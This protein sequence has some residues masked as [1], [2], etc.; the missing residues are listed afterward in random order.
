MHFLQTQ[1]QD[2]IHAPFPPNTHLV[3]LLLQSS[4]LLRLPV[5]LIQ[6]LVPVMLHHMSEVDVVAS[7]DVIRS[8]AVEMTPIPQLAIAL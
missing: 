7:R 6:M 2:M 8:T 3:A 1:P 5:L 4:Q